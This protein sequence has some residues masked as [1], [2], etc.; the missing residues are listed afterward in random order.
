MKRIN[1]Q[2]LKVLNFISFA[3]AL[4]LWSVYFI[5]YFD[6][7]LIR[8]SAD[9][10]V[11]QINVFSNILIAFF[12]L[13]IPLRTRALKGV[14]LFGLFLSLFS[15]NF[16][17]TDIVLINNSWIYF[18]LATLNKCLTG[19]VFVKALQSFP[20]QLTE[21]DIGHMFPR[22][23]IFG[24]FIKWTLKEYTWFL[25]PLIILAGSLLSVFAG[26]NLPVN[27]AILIVGFLCLFVN[28]KRSPTS[29][30]SKILWLFWGILANILIVLIELSLNFFNG[31]ETETLHNIVI[32]L[33]AIVL[34]LSLIMSLFFSD[35]F[36]TG[37]IITRTIAD[38]SVFILI[39]IIYNTSEHY[40]LHW[41]SH[42]L[43]L[44]DVLISSML[45][46]VF[47][48]LFSPVHHRLM[49]FLE[50]KLKYRTV[51]HA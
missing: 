7:K 45:S 36:N 47:V 35:T 5:K 44:S 21:Q 31:G 38:S 2:Q 19:T 20:Q 43:H 32:M 18:G 28:Y 25:F 1:L 50:R 12:S 23:N 49:H 17:L 13:I 10:L 29:G 42:E 48:M 26:I 41:L 33:Q 11:L 8:V 27:F 4:V 30:K 46:G 9:N 24:R 3:V 40:F 15:Q 6:H 37:A 34:V 16:A 22:A 39:V 51:Q 14:L